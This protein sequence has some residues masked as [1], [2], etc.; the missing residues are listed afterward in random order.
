MAN[1]QDYTFGWICALPTEFV[2]AQ[3]FLDE[4]HEGPTVPIIPVSGLDTR[5]RVPCTQRTPITA[6][7]MV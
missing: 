1:L 2:A 6:D 7:Q 5:N 3:A 4:E